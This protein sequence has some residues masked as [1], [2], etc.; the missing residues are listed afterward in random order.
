MKL[1]GF[2]D[3]NDILFFTDQLLNQEIKRN[4]HHRVSLGLDNAKSELVFISPWV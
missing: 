4:V 1:H 2:F 3:A